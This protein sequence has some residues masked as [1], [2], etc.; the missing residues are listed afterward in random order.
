MRKASVLVRLVV[1][2]WLLL[3][4]CSTKQLAPNEAPTVSIDSSSYVDIPAVAY[5]IGLSP[6]GSRLALRDADF[7][8]SVFDTKNGRR[9]CFTNQG[10][11]FNYI[12]FTPDNT[13]LFGVLY[14]TSLTGDPQYLARV[15]DLSDSTFRLITTVYNFTGPEIYDD[16][17]KIVGCS[18]PGQFMVYS[19]KNGSLLKKMTNRSMAIYTF[20][21]IRDENAVIFRDE[22]TARVWSLTNDNEIRHFVFEGGTNGYSAFGTSD[23]GHTLCAGSNYYDTRSG[24]SIANLKSSMW[25]TEHYSYTIEH[26]QGRDNIKII[27]LTDGSTRTIV[28][29][30]SSV[31]GFLN[32]SSNEQSIAVTVS[33][34]IS[35]SAIVRVWKLR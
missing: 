17:S 9:I 5:V 4:S 8:I 28:S 7:D 19:A 16:A 21:F 30:D 10:C 24:Q 6:D 35:P 22:D 27:K 11:N 2:G 32:V 15:Y 26:E 1:F 25:F 13:K 18:A 3:E 20:G 12:K 34:G 23:E 33:N 29:P 14:G 31:L